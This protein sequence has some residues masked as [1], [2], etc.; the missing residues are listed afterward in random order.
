MFDFLRK[1]KG[2][3]KSMQDVHDVLD[4]NEESH[5]TL[6]DLLDRFTDSIHQNNMMEPISE[7]ADHVQVGKT[8]GRK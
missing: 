2:S 5:S 7:V 4:D 3:A 6:S 8:D 1:A